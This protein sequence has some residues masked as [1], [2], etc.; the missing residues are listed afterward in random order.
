MRG[1][2][3]R[4]VRSTPTPCV[5][6]RT[7]TF[8]RRP[9][10]V[11]RITRPSKTWI[12]SRVPSTTLAWTRT[13]SPGRSSGIASF[14]CSFSSWSMTFMATSSI[15]NGGPGMRSAPVGD[16]GVVAGEQHFGDLEATPVGGPGELRVASAGRA[17]VLRQGGL[18]AQHAWDEPGHGVHEDHGRQLAAAEHVVADGDLAVGQGLADP[19]VD[20][21]VA[22]ADHDQAGLS[23]ELGRERLGQ[24]LPPRLHQDHRSRVGGAQRVDRGEDRLRLEHHA[25]AAPE[26]RVVD[27]AV[28][29][30][31]E[32]AEVVGVQRDEPARHRPADDALPEDRLEDLREDADDVEAHRYASSAASSQSAT[33]TVPPAMSTARTASGMTGI[34][35]SSPPRRAT[36][37]SFAGGSTTAVSVPRSRPLSLRTESPTR[38]WWYQ[39]PAGNGRSESSG[40]S[41]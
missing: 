14:C 9:P 37:T 38:S 22:A 30:D 11:T 13:V 20:A 32:V 18:V 1:E 28:P 8:W 40:T 35:S 21:L 5:T 19:V 15:S 10:P 3:T 7:V 29:V 36:H 34:R 12:R 33:V 16:L 31:R 26:R 6:R 39:R 25:G 4:N 41:R 23:R 2:C 27:L 24:R 17:G